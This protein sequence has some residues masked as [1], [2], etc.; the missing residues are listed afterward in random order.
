MSGRRRWATASP[1]AL[2]LALAALAAQAQDDGPRVYQLAPEGL[3]TLTA[4]LVDK[5][6]DEGPDPGQTAPGSQTRTDIFVLRYAR[7]FDWAGRQLTP[8]AILPWAG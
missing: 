8:F 1:A 6:G 5:R 3:Q 7:T 2:G 4:F